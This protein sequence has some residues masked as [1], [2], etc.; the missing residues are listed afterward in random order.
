MN[1]SLIAMLLFLHNRPHQFR[2]TIGRPADL[3]DPAADSDA[4]H[5]EAE[6]PNAPGASRAGVDR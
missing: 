1:S 2:R 6:V 5:A 4:Y 3:P